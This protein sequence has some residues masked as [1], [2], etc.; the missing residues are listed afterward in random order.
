MVLLEGAP[1]SEARWLPR[2][3]GSSWPPYP[4]SAL[5][6]PCRTE[7]GAPSRGWLDGAKELTNKISTTK[8]SQRITTKQQVT[9]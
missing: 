1:S 8:N 7:R 9:I 4:Q 3:H 6:P 5:A 2:P